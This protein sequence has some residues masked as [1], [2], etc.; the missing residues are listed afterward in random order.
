PPWEFI[1]E[2]PF[3]GERGHVLHVGSP[4]VDVA[5][6]DVEE[7]G[8]PRSEGLVPSDGV[9]DQLGDLDELEGEPVFEEVGAGGLD[10]GALASPTFTQHLFDGTRL[11]RS[12]EAVAVSCCAA[13][14]AGP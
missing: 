5:G 10:A 11:Q 4:C 6:G 8:L 2:P 13:A 12:Q 7:D 9:E 14:E 1:L 3:P